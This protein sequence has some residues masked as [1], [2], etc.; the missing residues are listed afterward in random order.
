MRAVS[1]A[2]AADNESLPAVLKPLEYADLPGWAEDDHAAAFRA[3]R[4]GTTALAELPPKTR[5]LGVDAAAL[6]ALLVRSREMHGGLSASDARHFFESAFRPFLVLPPT[7][8]GFFTGYYEPVVEGS[9]TRSSRFN[10]PLYSTPPDLIDIDPDAP[11]I[12]VE[13]GYRFARR[14]LGGYAPYPDR[15]EIEAGFLDRQ[16]LE[17]AFLADPVDAFFIHIQGAARIRLAEGGEMRVTYAAKNGHPYTPIG[18]VLIASGALPKGGATMQTIRAWLAAHPDE[19]PGVM[20]ANRSY[21]FFREAPVEDPALG[22]IAAAKVPLEPCRSLAADRLI[23]TFHTPV[24]VDTTLSSGEP[25]RRLMVIQ[26]TGSAIVG[27]ARGDIFFG[28]GAAAGDIAG[29]M[30][31]TGRFIVL[32]PRGGGP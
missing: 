12:G 13:R 24:F 18:R 20:A 21:I 31:A 27:P 32:L 4:R 28:S 8:S 15:A 5:S 9:R 10:V 1:P 17:I 3:F 6:A 29:A 30:Q 11:P 22:P 2:G 14:V 7:G 25:W 19:A 26:D 16:R 23:H